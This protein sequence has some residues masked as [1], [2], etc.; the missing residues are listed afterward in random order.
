[1]ATFLHQLHQLHCVRCWHSSAFNVWAEHAR[2]APS[3][4]DFNLLSDRESIVELDTEVANRALD[5]GVPKQ[6]LDGS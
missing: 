4:S 2:S 3:I 1:M 5:F 6:Q